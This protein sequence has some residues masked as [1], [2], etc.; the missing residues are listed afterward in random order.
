MLTPPKLTE[1]TQSF[2]FLNQ[3]NLLY[4]LENYREKII[5]IL[6]A[7]KFSNNC[8]EILC[9][10]LIFFYL[11]PYEITPEILIF[12][13][14][15]YKVI[16]TS[17]QTVQKHI[18]EDTS[19]TEKNNLLKE[20]L[21]NKLEFAL[22]IFDNNPYFNNLINSSLETL[23]LNEY[24]GNFLFMEELRVK[25]L[26][27]L[28]YLKSIKNNSNFYLL[29]E[30]RQKVLDETLIFLSYL[31]SNHSPN[32]K[33]PLLLEYKSYVEEIFSSIFS[34]KEGENNEKLVGQILTNIEKINENHKIEDIASL[35][36]EKWKNSNLVI[37]YYYLTAK[38]FLLYLK[39]IATPDK[40]RVEAIKNFSISFFILTI[41]YFLLESTFSN[42]SFLKPIA[43]FLGNHYLLGFSI[44]NILTFTYFSFGL[45]GI[46]ANT[47]DAYK[48]GFKIL[49][50]HC[51]SD[52]VD[53]LSKKDME[54]IPK[55]IKKICNQ[56]F[57]LIPVKEFFL[58]KKVLVKEAF[59]PFNQLLSIK[60]VK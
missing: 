52:K 9:K 2:N 7:L 38:N 26:F 11:R 58:L 1:Y 8:N 24:F 30:E 55:F 51:S 53:Y 23:D 49:K 54:E 48:E 35:L 5:L 56:W 31:L 41:I 10:N 16:K 33:K 57:L 21:S 50:M 37:N 47:I 43:Q 14:N 40:A 15:I 59:I 18:K 22:R 19:D 3:E 12:I 25:T 13:D 29:P 4:E 20:D 39:Q 27:T 6:R 34:F 45:I 60:E 46:I 32:I 17:I 28:K 42:V 36:L 44:S